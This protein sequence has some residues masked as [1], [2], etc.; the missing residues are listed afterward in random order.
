MGL[1][2]IWIGPPELAHSSVIPRF[3]L[4]EN[5]F[6]GWYFLSHEPEFPF[7]F[8]LAVDNVLDAAHFDFT[9]DVSNYC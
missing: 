9:H 2:W 3:V 5:I 4:R 1:V 7:S 8:D 6:E